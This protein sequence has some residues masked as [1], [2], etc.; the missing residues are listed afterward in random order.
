[1][2]IAAD[3]D[4]RKN[5]EDVTAIKIGDKPVWGAHWP[6]SLVSGWGPASMG[7]PKT[8]VEKKQWKAPSVS[9]WAPNPNTNIHSCTH[10]EHTFTRTSNTHTHTHT[11]TNATHTH[12]LWKNDVQLFV[13]KWLRISLVLAFV[14]WRGHVLRTSTQ[15]AAGKCLGVDFYA[16]VLPHPSLLKGSLWGS[17][18]QDSPCKYL[19]VWPLTRMA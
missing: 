14:K 10:T 5:K 15:G 19:Q 1:M 16:H 8:R 18:L 6:T 9:L 13:R 4:S 7:N 17:T 3:K 12:T 11:R 2:I